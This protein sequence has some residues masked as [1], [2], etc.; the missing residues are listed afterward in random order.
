MRLSVLSLATVLLIPTIVL[1]QQRGAVDAGSAPAPGQPI[2]LLAQEGLLPPPSV[3][4]QEWL[5]GPD[6]QDFAWKVQVSQDLTLQQRHLVQ[7]RAIVKESDLL[8]GVPRPELHIVTKVADEHGNWLDGQSYTH[9]V[10]P[11]KFS[12]NDSV[13]PF[14]NLYLRPG[15]YTI[16]MIAYDP[17]NHNG[18]VWR[19][20]LAISSTSGPSADLGRDFPVVEFLPP[21]AAALGLTS[22][23]W[24]SYPP[25]VLESIML[26]PLTLGHGIAHLPVE[27]KKP[28]RIDVIVDLS[29]VLAVAYSQVLVDCR[30]YIIAGDRAGEDLVPTMPYACSHP[31]FSEKDSRSYKY[32]EGLA[33][34]IGNLVSQLAPQAGCV[35][36]SAMDALREDLIAD[37]ANSSQVDWDGVS[38]RIASAELDKIDVSTERSRQHLV[39]FKQFIE[40]VTKDNYACGLPDGATDHVLVVISTAVPFPLYTEIDIV[41]SNS[42]R[43]RAYHLEMRLQGVASLQTANASIDQIEEVLS[44]LKPKRLQFLGSDELRRQLDFIIGDLTARSQ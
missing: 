43:P 35:R 16:A 4:V 6:R 29:D 1:A 10:Q 15:D 12:R 32:D 5:N 2:P 13:H 21:A 11:A 19:T 42:H 28:V 7:V 34:Q 37:R 36:F 26:D 40:K 31:K 23:D 20:K 3:P 22:A 24:D 9:F 41:K 27:N 39:W 38:K 44:P 17:V 30:N 8:G 33:L 25:A 14:A 18:N